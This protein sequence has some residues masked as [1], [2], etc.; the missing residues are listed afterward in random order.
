MLGVVGATAE[1]PMNIHLL[2]GCCPS[3][4]RVGAREKKNNKLAAYFSDH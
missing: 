3:N 1:N 4:S 2:G